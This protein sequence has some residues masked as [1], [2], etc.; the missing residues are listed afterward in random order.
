MF[1]QR[2]SRAVVVTGASS[3]I[4]RAIALA[5]AEPEASLWLCGRRRDA[6]DETAA[7]VRAAGAEPRPLCGDLGSEADIGALCEA[8]SGAGR[9]DV[10]VHAAALAA[11]GDVHTQPVADLDAQ[12]QVNLRAPYLLTQRLLPLLRDA[13][14]DIVFVNSSAALHPG[15]GAAAYAVTKAG[16]RA[17]ADS[18][19]QEV[20]AA[21]VRVMSVF[22]GRTATPMQAAIHSHEGREYRAERLMQPSDVAS[23]VA[24]A[25]RLPRTAEV[26]EISMR[27]AAKPA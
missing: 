3:G 27:P 23:M 5:L 2:A 12:L 21:G 6:L 22:P 26:M 9:L 7:A 11:L 25:V 16:L 18:V 17:L 19:R 15:A 4:G 20:N 1:D 8:V 24:A 13:G 10:L 14:G